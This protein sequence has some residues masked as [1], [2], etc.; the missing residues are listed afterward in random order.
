M[1]KNCRFPGSTGV[2]NLVRK[3]FI[4]DLLTVFL[5]GSCQKVQYCHELYKIPTKDLSFFL[6]H[7]TKKKYKL[8]FKIKKWNFRLVLFVNR[9]AWPSIQRCFYRIRTKWALKRYFTLWLCW[10][11]YGDHL[12]DNFWN[13][14]AYN[15]V[16]WQFLGTTI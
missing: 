14:W 12:I 8:V 2:R 5:D 10:L 15:P 3:N 4:L 13:N 16:I 11:L 7:E 9:S 6:S 1:L